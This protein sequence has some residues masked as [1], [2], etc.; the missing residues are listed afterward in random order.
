MIARKVRRHRPQSPP[1][2]Q[3]SAICLDV[4]APLATTSLTSWLVTPV[5]RQTNMAARQPGSSIDMR[6][7][8]LPTNWS[9]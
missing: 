8:N 2:P 1:A 3:A 9:G 6:W 4:V 7:A 5:H